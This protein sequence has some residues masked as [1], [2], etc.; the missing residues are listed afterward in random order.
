M[1]ETLRERFEREMLIRGYADRTSDAYVSAVRLMVRRTGLQPEKQNSVLSATWTPLSPP[2]PCGVGERVQ[3][4]MVSAEMLAAS[5]ATTGRS[6]ACCSS[7][8]TAEVNAAATTGRDFW[9]CANTSAFPGQILWHTGTDKVPCTK[10]AKPKSPVRDRQ[11]AGRGC[12]VGSSEAA[13]PHAGIFEGAA[14]KPAVLPR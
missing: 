3:T 1:S 11:L 5:G 9:R 14:G 7:G 6:C 12:R 13:K 2:R 4:T 8:S 10:R